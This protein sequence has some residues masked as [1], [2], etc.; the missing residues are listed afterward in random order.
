MRK[1]EEMGDSKDTGGPVYVDMPYVI[2]CVTADQ[3]AGS[4]FGSQSW[5]MRN[6]F[7]FQQQ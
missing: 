6:K 7:C 1:N 2:L 5:N 3:S 4:P